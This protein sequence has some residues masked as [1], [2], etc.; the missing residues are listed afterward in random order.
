MKLVYSL[1]QISRTTWQFNIHDVPAKPKTAENR[2][3]R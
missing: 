2:G 1:L 3:A